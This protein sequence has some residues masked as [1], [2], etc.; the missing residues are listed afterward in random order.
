MCE[1]ICTQPAYAIEKILLP[2]SYFDQIKSA[3]GSKGDALRSTFLI[4]GRWTGLTRTM[5]PLISTTISVGSSADF[6]K[7]SSRHCRFASSFRGRLFRTRA[8]H[9]GEL[10][11]R[12][13]TLA[14]YPKGGLNNLKRQI[15]VYPEPRRTENQIL[16]S[17]RPNSKS[18]PRTPNQL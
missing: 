12:G 2:G 9:R 8:S 3:A 11:L 10:V 5:L 15:V 13:P 17:L 6:G 18:S 1:R 7:H 14:R 16:D 4:G